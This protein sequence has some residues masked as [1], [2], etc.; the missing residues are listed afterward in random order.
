MNNRFDDALGL[1]TLDLNGYRGVV[2]CGRSGAGKSTAIRFLLEHHESFRHRRSEVDVIEELYDRQ[3]VRRF[4]DA[5][6]HDRPLLIASHWPLWLHR[7]LA[8]IVRVRVI[9]LDGPN[10]KIERALAFRSI[11]ATAR[12][13]DQF[14]TRFGANYTDL[15]LVL[16]RYPGLPFDV[17]WRRFRRECV[18]TE[19]RPS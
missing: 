14:C 6:K 15:E 10:I 12:A 19:S 5:I 16:E 17:A 11:P 4:T 2:F 3:D 9:D 7:L 13:I 1:R 8:P 18:V